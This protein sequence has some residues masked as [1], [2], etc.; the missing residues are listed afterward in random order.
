[1][2]GNQFDQWVKTASQGQTR[3]GL[4]GLLLGGVI[5]ASATGIGAAPR[6]KKPKKPCPT[7]QTRCGGKCVDLTT[8]NEHCGSCHAPHCGGLCCSGSCV[9]PLQDPNNCGQCGQEC[10]EAEE[11]VNGSCVGCPQGQTRCRP[12]GQP[13]YCADLSSDTSNC[14][15]CG[16]ACNVN[17]VCRAGQG[18]V[19]ITCSCEGPYCPPGAQTQRCCP[20]AGG[21]CCDDGRCCR[22]GEVCQPGDKCCPAGTTLCPDG[23]TC[24]P[25]GACAGGGQ[26][27]L[28][29]A[30]GPRRAGSR[31]RGV[32]ARTR[33]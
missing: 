2:D 10:S 15:Q 18:N 5:G 22:P 12:V 14:A 29:G 1:M 30:G 6:K 25:G 19:G 16:H 7:G 28:S 11:C 21:V 24:C 4:L 27:D 9:F 20:A 13:S 17:E 26:C 31:T 33:L 23:T 32:T 8:D 3:R